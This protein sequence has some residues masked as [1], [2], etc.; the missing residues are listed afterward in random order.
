MNEAKSPTPAKKV[1]FAT[2]LSTSFQV[3][4]SLKATKKT[5]AARSA[6][7]KLERKKA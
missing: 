2:S 3:S 4:P 5:S 6:Y 1:R 7:K